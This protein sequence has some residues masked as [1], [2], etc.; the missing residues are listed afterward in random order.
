MA[1]QSIPSTTE[2][3]VDTSRFE[4]V[5]GQLLERPLPTRSHAHLQRHFAN[6]LDKYLEGSGFEVEAELSIDRWDEKKS[7]WLTPDVL[8]S[9][10]GGFREARGGHALSPALLAIEIL[11]PGQNL[12][13]MRHKASILIDWG[14]EQIWLAD[15]E[16]RSI[17]VF[18]KGQDTAK[19]EVFYEG[20]MLLP[21]TG[22]HVPLALIFS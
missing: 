11:S 4:R 7:D 14:V 6:V 18:E 13:N 17:A 16:S 19:S 20:D 15:P 22:I 3:S 10:A 12:S 5:N 8:V 1:T 9:A 2:E 21:S